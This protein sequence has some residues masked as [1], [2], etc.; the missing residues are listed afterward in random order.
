MAKPDDPFSMLELLIGLPN[1]RVLSVDRIDDVL[2]IHLETAEP[3]RF[4]KVCGM[5]GVVKDRP[6]SRYADLPFGGQQAVL[7]WHKYRWSCPGGDPSWTEERGDIATRYSSAMTW[8]A[9]VWATIAVGRHVRPVSQVAAELGVAWNTLMDTV[10]NVGAI[11]IDHVDR[12]GVTAQL[13]VDETVFLS[14][15]RRRRRQFVS[16]VTD[17]EART[18]LDVFRGRQRADLVAWFANRPTH[19]V[20]GVKVVVADLH[21]PFRNAF[22]ECVPDAVKVADPMHVVM[23]A[24]RCPDKT[25]R[26]IQNEQLAHRGRKDDPLFGA[27]KLLMLGAERLDARS[28]KRLDVL[29]AFG[30][31]D[32]HVYEAWQAKENVRDLYTLWGEPELAAMWIDSIIDDARTSPIPEIKGLGRT[33]RQWRTPILA[34]HTTGASNGPTE[35]LNSII[36]K[37]KRVAAGFTNFAH[38]RTRILLAIGGCNWNL[39]A[40]Q[41]R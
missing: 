34:W 28:R 11:M 26:R 37:I 27:R 35:G 9:A 22:E 7:V 8:R 25:R 32:G 17:V 6:L 24:N 15:G 19:W 20:S 21:E 38:Y 12:I 29:L 41:P 18:V 3:N 36:K 33:L 4:C 14:A 23:A 40:L 31:P 10:T 1:V 30:D 2:E 39:I 5:A 16:S 13:G